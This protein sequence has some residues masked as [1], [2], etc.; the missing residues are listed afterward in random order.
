MNI[1]DFHKTPLAVVVARVRSEA[2]GRGRIIGSSELVGLVPRDALKGSTPALLGLPRFHPA[3][4]V[5]AH[6]GARRA[7]A[8]PED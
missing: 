8:I 1:E 7:P 4:L 5:E 3:Q 2:T 6:V